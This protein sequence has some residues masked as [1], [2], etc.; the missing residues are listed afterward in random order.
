MQSILGIDV[1]KKTL[2]VVLLKDLSRQHK[3][4][5]NDTIGYQQLQRWL[6]S[7]QADCVHACLE[8]TGQYGDGVAEYLYAEHH[9]VSVVNPARIKRYGESKLHRNKTDKADAFLIAEFCLKEQPSLWHPLSAEIKHLRALV[10]HLHDLQTNLNQETNRLSAGEQDPWVLDDLH[11]HIDYLHARI[12]ATLK[13]MQQFISQTPKLK[14]QQDLLISIPGI[15]ELTAA[16]LLAEI[17]DISVFENAPQ[18]AAYAGLNPR[19]FRSGSSVH[20][21]SI[22]SKQG[23]PIL[24]QIL[25]MPAVSAKRYNPVICTF[26]ARLKE[27]DLPNMAIISAAMRKLLHQVYGVL[28]NQIP[29]D[30]S[31]GDQFNFG[32]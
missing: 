2:D 11:F 17:G 6:L 9:Q 21:K 10:R 13:A 22:I 26:C 20:K 23:R 14:A 29:F 25:Y 28:K 1:S 18:L 27:R 4:F 19:G 7:C 32:A 5:N 24:R 12:K 31:Y 30:P 3:I 15:A 8:A 16:K